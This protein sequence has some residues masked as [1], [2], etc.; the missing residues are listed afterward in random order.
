MEIAIMEEGVRRGTMEIRG[1]GAYTRFE[2]RCAPLPGLRRLYVFGGG[3]RACLGVLAPE[4]GELRLRRRL[5]RAAM[6]G[7]PE[8][9]EFAV[10][11]EG[12]PPEEGAPPKGED[13]E[14]DAPAAGAAWER[15]A[16]GSL[17]GEEEGRRLLALPCALRREPP[18]LR[19]R[20]IG[21][22]RY[23]VFHT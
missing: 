12:A 8:R 5:S 23:L 10:A 1:E 11:A 17:V 3:A 6:E 4:G 15:R 9:I 16:D 21:G 20:E 13:A 19:L 14:T 7:F 2:A 22:R 18:G